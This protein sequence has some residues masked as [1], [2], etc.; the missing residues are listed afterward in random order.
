MNANQPELMLRVQ[1]LTT[2]DPQGEQ[3]LRLACLA[4]GYSVQHVERLT[5]PKP[6]DPAA[7]RHSLHPS[8][9][10]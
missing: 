2:T 9:L 1:P 4:A 10:M 7:V 6:A 8:A 3:R 5:A